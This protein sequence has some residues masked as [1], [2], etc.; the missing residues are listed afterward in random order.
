MIHQFVLNRSFNVLSLNA[1]HVILI[2][3]RGVVLL[4]IL[5]G[6]TLS[7]LRMGLLIFT[8]FQS[9]YTPSIDSCAVP[10]IISIILYSCTIMTY[11]MA[12]V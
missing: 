10:T 11:W 12:P 9:L 8:S 1:D 3:S 7:L 2:T 5:L 6:V 4:L